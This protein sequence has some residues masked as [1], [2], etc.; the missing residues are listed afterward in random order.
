MKM[1]GTRVP[2]APFPL[3]RFNDSDSAG[4]CK[5]MSDKDIGG[6]SE[7]N[8]DW[9]PASASEPA[10]I[11][12]HGSISTDLPTNQPEVQRTGYAGWR[13]LDRPPTL[14][15]KSLWDIDPFNFLALRVK[16]DGRRYFVNLQTESI[17]PT[18]LHQH[19]LYVKKPGQWETVVINWGDFVRTNHG[20]VVEPQGEILRQ[21]LKTIG[22][23]LTDRIPGPFDICIS[24]IWATNALSEEEKNPESPFTLAGTDVLAR[25]GGNKLEDK[26]IEKT[27]P[28]KRLDV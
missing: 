19:R 2:N 10:H 27:Y 26:P 6:F 13:N 21:K 28:K 24:N 20:L 12:F 22:F 15:G 4:D 16:S 5:K 9:V 3:L 17:V 7:A 1:E 8:L 18:D 23:S 14:F 25:K 11:R